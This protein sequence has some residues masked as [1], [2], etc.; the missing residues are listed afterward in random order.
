MV[1]AVQFVCSGCE[2]SFAKTTIV[3]STELSKT[4]LQD[5]ERE[6]RDRGGQNLVW[7]TPPGSLCR[8]LDDVKVTCERISYSHQCLA[9]STI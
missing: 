5:N 4:L 8:G 1:C 7:Q 9:L 2:L 6:G 3:I